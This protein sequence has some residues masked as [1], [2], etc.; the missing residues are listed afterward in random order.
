[1][2]KYLS[3]IFVLVL[4]FVL[5]GCKSDE[6]PS[7]DTNDPN[8]NTDGGG[9]SSL[10]GIKIVTDKNNIKV[11]EEV[12]AT[13]EFNPADY[14]D[15]EV[16]WQSADESI[17]TVDASGKITGVKAGTANIY[18][19]LKSSM[20]SANPFKGTKKINVTNAGDD[21]SGD[22]PD[23]Q[24]YTIRIAQ[25]EQ[26]LAELDPFLPG[27]GSLNRDAK[28]EAW[29]EVED[30]FNCEIEVVAYPSTAPWGPNRWKYI[31][32]QAQAGVSDYDFL[33]VPDARIPEFVEAG[34]LINIEDFYTL[35]GDEFMDPSF[36]TSGSYKGDMYLIAEGENNI[37]SVMYYNIGLY[38][39]LKAV[40]PT[41]KEPAE[42][43]LEGQWTYTMF[44][45]YCEQVQKAMAQA[46]PGEGEAGSESQNYFAVSGWDGY[47]W[48]GLASTD[49]KPLADLSTMS[50]DID[51]DTKVAAAETVRKVYEKGLCDPAQRV[52]E[53]VTSW[54]EGRAF[55]NTGDLWFVGNESRWTETM[56]GEENTK[57]GYVP[58]PMPDT[59]TLADYKIALGG[60]AGDVM[61]IGRDYSGYGDD[62]TAEN[63]Y[64]AYVL[65]MQKT[66]EYYYGSDSY[67]RDTALQT[68]AA[69]YAHS[70][71]SQ[72]A[73]IYIANQ[74]EEGNG[75]Y[76]PLTVNDNPIDS[77]YTNSTTGLTT[78]KAAVQA[79]CTTRSVDTWADAV[80]SLK[81]ILEESMR[82]NYS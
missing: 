33:R 79:Y 82:K 11:G 20:D 60:T 76:D 39:Q 4:A 71:A 35:H 8:I 80:V 12:Q 78:I 77:A 14:A 38:E 34:A 18:A 61:P 44:A 2:K 49:G 62:C 72:A 54:N 81:P 65:M 57:Y 9:T 75:F 23:L 53:A 31:K 6:T 28:Q 22:Y 36:V 70:E 21:A 52:D 7:D 15:Q 5:I 73:Y 55:F 16:V 27:Y 68:V 19:I 59:Y 13:V 51:S 47:W 41:L 58:W 64:W 3:L 40:D 17:V 32:D 25:A 66:K 45:S 1:M 30:L 48:R 69:K 63:I 43:F 26:A 37:Y 10:K 42:I 24:G 56:W 50:I 74:I 29:N 46:F 67:D